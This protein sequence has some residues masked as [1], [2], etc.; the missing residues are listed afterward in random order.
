MD[1]LD[2]FTLIE[3]SAAVLTIKIV[4][5]EMEPEVAEILEFPVATLVARPWLPAALLMVAMEPFDEFHC[6][7]PVMSCVLPSVKVPVALNCSVVP[8][9]MVGIAGVMARETNVAGVTVRVDEPAMLAA[10]A[11]MVV[12]PVE[13][14]VATP[15]TLTFATDG[16]E[17]LQIA[18]AV[19]SRVLPSA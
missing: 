18:D 1:G 4:E 10:V 19:R 3:T 16:S 17:E 8:R 13:A 9:G 15:L 7:E 11:V 14:L 6:T 5:T 2:G 12:C